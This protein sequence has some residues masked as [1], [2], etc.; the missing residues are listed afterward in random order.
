MPTAAKSETWQR[1]GETATQSG[2]SRLDQDLA[3][4]NLT[5]QS[6]TQ[7][8]PSYLLPEM[9]GM[10]TCFCYIF[11]SSFVNFRMPFL[12]FNNL[13]FTFR[14]NVLTVFVDQA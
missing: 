13:L 8:P 7:S 3:R 2:L 6:W 5:G 1:P 12:C 14:S 10:L 4:L 11:L 9:R